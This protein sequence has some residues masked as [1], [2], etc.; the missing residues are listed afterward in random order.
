MDLKSRNFKRSASEMRISK[1]TRSTARW[2]SVKRKLRT[3]ATVLVWSLGAIGL[4]TPHAFAKTGKQVESQPASAIDP[5][6]TEALNAMG[7]YLRTLQSFQ[8]QAALSTDDVAEDGQTIQSNSNVDLLAV[9]PNRLRADVTGDDVNRVYL[10]DGKNFT[11]FGKQTNYYATVPAPATI[12]E[13]IDKLTDRF[14]I[15]LPLVDLFRWGTDASDAKNIKTA[16]DVGPTSI[17][18]V[19]CEQYAFHQDDIDWQIWIQLGQF[20]L[21]RKVVIRTL[22]EAAKP[23]HSEVLTWNLA[24]S[25][26]DVAFTFDPPADAHRIVL[27]DMKAQSTNKK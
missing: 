17:D 23:Q 8:V 14:D 9:R 13:L 20:P 18:G 3:A 11:V 15:D 2:C 7:A 24:P 10:Y 16:I 1:P 21:P 5:H 25:F 26:N 4:V 12:A 6:A 22:T 19:T 27:E